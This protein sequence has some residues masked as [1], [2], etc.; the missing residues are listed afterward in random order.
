[1]VY[2]KEY[3]VLKNFSDAAEE[4]NFEFNLR[5]LLRNAGCV[6]FIDGKEVSP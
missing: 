5:K 3:R 4:R 2:G 1:M 6:L